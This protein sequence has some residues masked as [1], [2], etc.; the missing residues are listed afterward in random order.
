MFEHPRMD[1]PR[2][3]DL[4]AEILDDG[5]IVRQ[6]FSPVE[7]LEANRLAEWEKLRD[8][9]MY[10]NR[11]FPDVNIKIELFYQR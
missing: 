9:L 6:T 11:F 3:K 10:H 2:A 5:E 4:L 1:D 8:E 7:V